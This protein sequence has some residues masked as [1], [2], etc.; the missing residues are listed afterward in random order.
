MCE[1]GS[2]TRI[3]DSN[4]RRRKA[5]RAVFWSGA[6]AREQLDKADGQIKE[7]RQIG[8]GNYGNRKIHG[9]KCT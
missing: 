5:T 2:L 3:C 1:D 7:A 8:E 4:C 9:A 6:A